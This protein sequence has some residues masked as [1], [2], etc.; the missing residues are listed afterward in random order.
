MRQIRGRAD[1]D[2]K[3]REIIEKLYEAWCAAPDLRLGQLLLAGVRYEQLFQ[4]EDEPLAD[5]VSR[6]GLL[7]GDSIK[8][9]HRQRTGE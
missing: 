1:T 4:I 2:A 9:H 7:V 3:K 6:L 8:Y 5:A